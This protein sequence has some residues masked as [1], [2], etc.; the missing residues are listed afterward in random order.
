M[1]R[2]VIEAGNALTRLDLSETLAAHGFDV[3]A[4]AGA[5]AGCPLLAGTPCSHLEG[6]DVVVNALAA[7]QTEVYIA[8]RE[9]YPDRAVL[10]LTN[11]LHETE[12]SQVLD[13]VETG[14]STA[15]GEALAARVAGLLQ[16][17]RS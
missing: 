9:R 3:V 16:E 4:C 7:R 8:Q 14:P 2:V 17:R 11:C 5:T 15:G 1:V 10:L 12:L 6:A 13:D